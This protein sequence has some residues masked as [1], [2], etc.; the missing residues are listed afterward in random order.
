M[1]KMNKE[2]GGKGKQKAHHAEPPVHAVEPKTLTE[3]KVKRVYLPGQG[4]KADKDLLGGKG[5]NLQEMHNIGI[6]VP[7]F[8]QITT[9]VCNEY[10]ESGALPPELEDGMNEG[11][12][13]LEKAMDRKFADSK[14][15]LLLSVRSGARVSMPGM[16]D[17]VLN[18]GLNDDTVKGLASQMGE[19]AALDCYRRFISMFSD[20]VMGIDKY[21]FEEVL[22]EVKRQKNVEL[23]TE[24][25][26]DDL[27]KVV[28]ESK[29][30]VIDETARIDERIDEVG[31][32]SDL[33]KQLASIKGRLEKD[34][35]KELPSDPHQQLKM[36][37]EAVFG[38]WMNPRAIAYRNREGI[39]H[40]WGT[41]VNVQAM[42]YGN[43]GEDSATGVAFTRNPATG[44]NEFYGDFLINAQG[45]D[46]V[47][48]V[49][50]PEPLKRMEEEFSDCYEEL[51]AIREKLEK[52]QG[53][54]Q[55]I[56]FTIQNR[57]LWMLQTRDGKRTAPAAVRV[58]TEMLEEGLMT[59]D[60][61]LMKVTPEQLDRLLHPQIDPKAKLDVIAKG[62]ASSPGAGRGLVTFTSPDATALGETHEGK[63]RGVI[64]LTRETSPDDV[65]GIIA[66]GN[67]G[68]AVITATGGP[69]C[70][71]AIVTRG[72]GIPS[73]VGVSSISID[74]GAKKA[75]VTKPDGSTV[76]INAGD[77][78]TVDGATGEV[79]LGLAPMIKPDIENEWLQKLL[80]LADERRTLGVHANAELPEDVEQAVKFGADGIGLCRT[81]HMFIGSDRL[82]QF[83]EVILAETDEIRDK[84]LEV[85]LERQK[86]DFSGIFKALDGK[87]AIIRLL[88]PP[89]HEFLPDGG[90]ISGGLRVL[91]NL[92]LKPDEEEALR[93]LVV[94]EDGEKKVD[95]EQAPKTG[96]LKKLDSLEKEERED[97]AYTLVECAHL[98]SPLIETGNRVLKKVEELSEVN[99]MMG[100]RGCRLGILM[101]GI[102][103][104]QARAIFEA[105]AE[106][107]NTK[108]KI[109]VPLVGDVN[110]L[111]ATKEIIDEVAK[112]VGGGIEYEVGTM[113]EVPRA[114]LTADQIGE[115]AD[116]FSFGTN[117]LTQ[118]TFAFS[119]DDV[120]GKVVVP[121][122]EQGILANDPFQTLD[123]TGV[124]KLVKMAVEDGRKA[125]PKL[126]IGICGE[127]GGDPA[128]IE[129]CHR[130]GLD[131]VSCSPFR[132]PI[133]RL[134]AAQANIMETQ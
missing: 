78:L 30:I 123:Q 31:K 97:L 32:D 8:F 13:A 53:D 86:K 73:V 33:G 105:A 113:I 41:A 3:G 38:S 102:T 98:E 60:E 122:I 100:M 109:M 52:N 116:F 16:M 29:K 66:A 77:E 20:V 47:A 82:P 130:N 91:N 80:N 117:D 22:S 104:M 9:R 58:A 110:E 28:E 15:P 92:K 65:S 90:K 2:M 126:S 1:S 18:L 12:A 84:G 21:K 68:G 119:R 36:A 59:A 75:T 101:P 88:D 6:P 79:I 46:V 131:Y 5:A 71:A 93:K 44:E 27:R 45:E 111:K 125:N 55:D 19:R 40:D 17:T 24:L 23:D 115:V 106:V 25:D 95:F 83:R 69:T 26:A 7:A 57:K 39:P 132:V 34:G 14:T 128:S 54:M 49:R 120:G 11:I 61:A 74:E 118:F 67:T 43:M 4:T 63:K 96:N 10:T 50:T 129:F 87:P 89:L 112:E 133:A 72:W 81:E 121:Y 42:V 37:V 108:P 70:H 76:E 56:E 94:E 99:P 134:A 35:V 114:A 107:G 124:G 85:L 48:G 64:L 103:R 62:I 127:H 51:L